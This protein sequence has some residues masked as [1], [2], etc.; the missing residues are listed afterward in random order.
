MQKK[1]NKID[2]WQTFLAN[3][4]LNWTYVW[5][6]IETVE[7]H[8]PS[9]Y[10]NSNKMHNIFAILYDCVYCS[11]TAVRW[12][13]NIT[14]SIALIFLF[15]YSSRFQFSHFPSYCFRYL[16]ILMSFSCLCV[17]FSS[18]ATSVCV[19]KQRAFEEN[20]IAYFFLYGLRKINC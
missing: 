16:H 18:C 17:F 6:T 8:R 10:I 11:R 20:L 9:K 14:L 15:I 4:K 13:V 5:G 1:T 3:D 12:C 2:I 7:K 19:Y